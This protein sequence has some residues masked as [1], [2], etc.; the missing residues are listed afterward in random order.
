MRPIRVF[1]P[2]KPLLFH[3]RVT[4]SERRDLPSDAN[5]TSLFRMSS[6]STEVHTR[7]GADAVGQALDALIA[8]I[9]GQHSADNPPHIVGIARGGIPL[10]ERIANELSKIWGIPL[11]CGQIDI[12]FHRDDI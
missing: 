11:N 12:S 2:D 9:V 1:P 7:I 4:A 10:A 5:S 8:Q 6:I 3:S